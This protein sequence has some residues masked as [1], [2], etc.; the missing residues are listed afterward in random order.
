L[1]GQT[2]FLDV[3]NNGLP[4]DGAAFTATTGT[5]GTFTFPNVPTGTY[6]LKEVVPAGYVQSGPIGNAYSVNVS[7]GSALTGYTFPNFPI[8]YTGT[9]G[10]DNYAAQL[11]PAGTNFQVLVGGSLTY[12]APKTL[13]ASLPAAMSFSLLGGDDTL[14]INGANGGNPVPASPG[15]NF[16]G[17][18][19]TSGDTLSIIG[20]AG[21]DTFVVSSTA[22]T[23]GGNPINYTNTETVLLDPGAGSDALTVNSG[24]VHF[25]AQTSGGGILNRHFS[26][27]TINNSGFAVVNATGAQTDRTALQIDSLTFGAGT[28]QLDITNNE[29]T[30][31]LALAT[32]SP[33]IN[34]QIIS[35]SIG[36]SSP[37]AIGSNAIG[38]SQTRIRFTY[39]G[40]TDLDGHVNVADLANL[41]G[42]FG[43][44]T[45]ATWIQGDFDY[46]GSV[47]VADLADLAGN[48]GLTLT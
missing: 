28:P 18:T 5:G 22:V 14:I 7:A 26:N 17:G 13:L 3:N 38:A 41:A 1:S 47:N 19:H 46:N 44:T 29:A 27:L 11:D 33:F 2:V 31:N 36:V 30:I 39:L 16:D 23:F 8:T 12:Q 10:N 32:V 24:T 48:F 42:N 9:S 45:G 34:N 20:T 40:D 35:S 25:P 43:K 4:D 6:N 21:N 37:F 15:I